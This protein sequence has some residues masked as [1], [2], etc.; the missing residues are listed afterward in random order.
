MIKYPYANYKE[1]TVENSPFFLS[2][3]GVIYCQQ[4]M[5]VMNVVEDNCT[6]TYT[7]VKDDPV[8]N[9]KY[10]FIPKSRNASWRYDTHRAYPVKPTIEAI[11]E[12]FKSL[13]D[14]R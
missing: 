9:K 5:H 1:L 6:E 4:W 3:L 11:E 14:L 8:D 10:F 7:H 12:L 13:S 2:D